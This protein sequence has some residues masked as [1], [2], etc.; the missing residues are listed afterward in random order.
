MKEGSDT[1]APLLVVGIAGAGK[2]ALMARCAFDATVC[3]E[4]GEINMPAL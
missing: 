4:Q 1:G 3:A 2:S